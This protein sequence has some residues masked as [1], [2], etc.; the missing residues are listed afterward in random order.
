[1]EE[2]RQRLDVLTQTNDGFRI[3]EED[4]RIRGPGQLFG[5]Q[6]SGMPEFR[7]YDFSDTAIL[8]EARDD[9]FKLVATDAGLA[10][11]QHRL[12]RKKVLEEYG[13]SLALAD[14]V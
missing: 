2:A 1:T 14:V 12:L 10:Q 6:Q 3:A 8:K 9:A 4:L 7:C 13:R 5:T 11:P